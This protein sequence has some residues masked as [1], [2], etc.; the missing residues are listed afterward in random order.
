MKEDIYRRIIDNYL[1]DKLDVI[2]F[3][4]RFIHQWRR[5][6]SVKVFNDS[7][8]QWFINRI[9]T[10]CNLYASKPESHFEIDEKQLREEVGRFRNIW[11]G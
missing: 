1:A 3:T 10:S 4:D 8:F 9:F 6:K 7:R 2:K 5:D 11:Y